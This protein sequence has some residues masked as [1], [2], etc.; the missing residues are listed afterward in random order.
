MGTG[1]HWGV[2]RVAAT[3]HLAAQQAPDPGPIAERIV[4]V[5]SIVGGDGPMWSPDGSRILFASSLG[6]PGVRS[7]PSGGGAPSR[8]TRE[9]STQLVRL[10]PKGDALAFLSEKS[11]N[12]ELWLWD[13][14]R[15]TERRL[16][17]LGARINAMSWS[18]DGLSIAFSEIGRAH[19]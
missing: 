1:M 16:T 9:I 5:G 19:V 4:S 14:A 18:P 17:N 6:G 8:V 15:G 12:P 11:G 10:A 3:L 7:V 2:L 13:M